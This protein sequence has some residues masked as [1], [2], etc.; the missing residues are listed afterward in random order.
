MKHYAIDKL[1]GWTPDLTPKP[2]TPFYRWPA[3]AEMVMP[4]RFAHRT[5]GCIT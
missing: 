3:L 4:V 5:D 1:T 2:D